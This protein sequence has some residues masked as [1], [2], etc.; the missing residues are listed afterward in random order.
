[1]GCTTTQQPL[2]ITILFNIA[3][4]LEAGDPVFYKS[5]QVGEVV[6]VSAP[7]GSLSRYR[8]VEVQI[9]PEYAPMMYRQIAFTVDTFRLLNRQRRIVAMDRVAAPPIPIQDGDVFIGTTYVRYLFGQTSDFAVDAIEMLKGLTANDRT[10]AD[11]PN[12]KYPN[13]TD[14]T[15]PDIR[16]YLEKFL[17]QLGDM[18]RLD[19][20]I[21]RQNPGRLDSV[22]SRFN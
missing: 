6:S 12:G 9:E 21:T 4:K 14:V 3:P 22:R 13:N 19:S 10:P 15:G 1:M 2:F 17:T 11:P 5:V 18:S 16:K 7:A 20:L 8:V